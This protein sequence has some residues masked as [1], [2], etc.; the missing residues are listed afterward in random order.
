MKIINV[1]FVIFN[2][3]IG[4]LIISAAKL[5]PKYA[6]FLHTWDYLS[7]YHLEPY[8]GISAA[9]GNCSSS[10]IHIFKYDVDS[11]S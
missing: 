3:T 10:G 6:T 2:Y 5:N 8:F 11:A 9:C 7:F 1:I 4:L